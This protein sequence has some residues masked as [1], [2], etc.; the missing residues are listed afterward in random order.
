MII[1]NA[2]E[3]RRRLSHY[4]DLVERGYEVTIIRYS[5]PICILTPSDDVLEFESK[6]HKPFDWP[7]WKNS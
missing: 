4:L 2:K 5:F 3:F 6:R 7:D 1:V